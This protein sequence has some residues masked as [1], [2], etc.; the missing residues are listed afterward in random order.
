M[1]A[2]IPHSWETNLNTH[3]Q[4]DMPLS[5]EDLYEIHFP[6]G[7]TTLSAYQSLL[8]AKMQLR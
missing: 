8:P 4:K 7:W 2:A 3:C 1:K 5:V 6:E